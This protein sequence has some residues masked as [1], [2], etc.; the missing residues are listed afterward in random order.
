MKFYLK[1]FRHAPAQVA[2]G[3]YASGDT[4]GWSSVEIF[5]NGG[6][7]VMT[8][9][10]FRQW[11]L[12]RPLGNFKSQMMLNLEL[13]EFTIVPSIHFGNNKIISNR[14]SNKITNRWNVRR[15]IF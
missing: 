1:M 3:E 12:Q 6:Q 8:R 7:Y 14:Y 15:I 4:M 9:Q 13:D 11:T 5:I 2:T 10:I